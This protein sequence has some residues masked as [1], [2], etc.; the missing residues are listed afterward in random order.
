M[1]SGLHHILLY[2]AANPGGEPSAEP[3]AGIARGERGGILVLREF[4][5]IFCRKGTAPARRRPR[6]AARTG[7]GATLA[8][9]EI[10]TKN[11]FPKN[12]RHGIFFK[13][14]SETSNFSEIFSPPILAVGAPEM[15]FLVLRE[16]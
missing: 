11:I 15:P 8:L 9:W 4:Q 6:Q 13:I 7:R 14:P 3:K 2:R 10:F 16:F 1:G 12:G 5:S